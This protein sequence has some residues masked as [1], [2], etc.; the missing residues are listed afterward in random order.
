MQT[1][2]RPKIHR[3]WLVFT[4]VCIYYFV[5]Y[6]LIYSGFGLFLAPMSEDLGIPYVQLSVTATVRVLCG[7]VTTAFIGQIFSRVRLRQFLSVVLLVM[8]AMLLLVAASGKLWQFIILFAVMGLCCGMTLYGVV[9]LILNQWFEAPAVLITIATA[10]GGAGGVILCP[11]LS[12]VIHAWG[13]RLGYVFVAALVL[14]VMFPVAATLF[15]FSPVSRGCLPLANKGETK[16]DT[17]ESPMARQGRKA[18]VVLYALL[19]VFF[20][21]GALAGGMYIHISSALYSKGFETLRVSLLVSCFQA[22]TTLFQM[23]PGLISA[24][25][26]LRGVTSVSLVLV[27]AGAAALVFFGAESPFVFVFLAVLLVGG[28]RLFTALNP[29]LARYVFGQEGFHK[30]YPKLQSIYLIGTA[31]TSIIYG[32]IYSGTGS[33][34]GSLWLM[35]ACMVLLL[36]VTQI[37]FVLVDHVQLKKEV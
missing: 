34:N 18:P 11:L 32:G 21:A 24:R 16:K 8:A 23:V 2:T 20:L 22:G 29:L 9:P 26:G 12:Q 7:M 15:D 13:W 3:A 35:V 37:I 19:A 10:C 17:S 36:V 30:T 1:D 6:G 27:A 14:L 31:F 25:L 33:Y 28:G 4:G 5:A